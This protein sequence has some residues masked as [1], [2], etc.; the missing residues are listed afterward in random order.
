[1]FLRV[2]SSTCCLLVC[3]D[4][5]KEVIDPVLLLSFLLKR[6]RRW[7]S[8]YKSGSRASHP[9]YARVF[10]YGRADVSSPAMEYF[11]DS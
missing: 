7:T 3:T 6:S 11:P 10:T 5:Q 1:M 8:C 9:H 4:F 2:C